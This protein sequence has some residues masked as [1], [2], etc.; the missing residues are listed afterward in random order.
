MT[1]NGVYYIFL[2]EGG[3]FDFT[4]NG[5]KYL[6]FTAVL[7]KRPF[8]L[9]RALTELRFDLI[10]EGLELEEFHATEDRQHTRDRVFARISEDLPSL[11]IDSI[12]VEKSK[13][14]PNLQIPEQFYPKM[15]GYLL[16]WI[17]QK[18]SLANASEIIVVTDEIPLKKKRNAMEKAIKPTLKYMLPSE[19]KHR[20]MHHDSKSCCGLQVADYANWAIYRKWKDNDTRSYE[21]IE[22][23]IRSEFPIFRF[24]NK[25]WY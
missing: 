21:I 22:E 7:M 1:S 16:R 5:T 23:G 4:P 6:T 2:D 17:I 25:H 19:A 24:G 11:R 12:I 15:L 9:D 10:E 20:I 3:N 14:E 8:A 18:E 13:T